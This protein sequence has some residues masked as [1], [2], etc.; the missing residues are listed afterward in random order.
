MSKR[1]PF[2]WC[3]TTL[4]ELR[5]EEFQG[6][7]VAGGADVAVD[8]V[9]EPE[10]GVGGV[11][12]A[13]AVALGVQVRDQAVA[14]GVGEGPE[15]V[16]GLA[17]P[18]GAEGQP[19]E[20]D[21]GVAAPVGEP[22][23][24][25]DHGPQLVAGGAGA[26]GVLDPAGGADEELVGG[27]HQLGGRPG[28]GGPGRLLDQPAAA[29]ELGLGGLLGRQGLDG[30][31]GLGRGDQ[32]HVAAGLQ[33][34]P[35]VAGAPEGAGGGIAAVVLEPVVDLVDPGPLHRVGRSLADEPEP[36]RGQAA[37]LAEL[38]AVAGGRQ[39][40]LAG[41]LLVDLRVVRAEVDRRPELQ[42]ERPVAGDQPVAQVR[43]VLEVGHQQPL[44]DGVP[45]RELVAPDG[46]AVVEA[47]LGEVGGA[48][49]LQ[50]VAAGPLLAAEADDR[51]VGQAE[52]VGEVAEHQGPAVV[53]GQG[54]D[55]QA[56]VAAG[57][58]ARERPRGVAAEAV[59][60]EPL[61]VEQGP[62]VGLGPPPAQRPDRVKSPS[63]CLL[64]LGSGCEQHGGVPGEVPAVGGL[65]LRGAGP[66]VLGLLARPADRPGGARRRGQQGLVDRVEVQGPAEVDQQQAVVVLGPEVADEE[67][68]VVEDRAVDRPPQRRLAAA[69]PE[70]VAVEPV[71]RGSPSP[72]GVVELAA[73]EGLDGPG[74]GQA[75]LDLRQAEVVEL[76]E[77]LVVPLADELRQLGRV[78][79]EVE[80]R[81][82]RGV[83]LALE[84]HRGL[85]RR[86]ARAPS[87][88]GSGRPRRSGG[89]ARPAASWPA[90]RGS[91]G[92]RR[93]ARP[94]GPAPAGPD[95][96]PGG[97]SA[98]PGRASRASGPRRTPGARPGSRRSRRRCGR[99]GRRSPRGGSRRTRRRRSRGRPG[100]PAGGS[101]RPAAR[102][103]RRSGCGDP[104]R[105]RGP[106]G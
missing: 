28:T 32:G 81:P 73:L 33:V 63:G 64:G 86:A 20:A 67:R 12:E 60:H 50:Q 85:R 71:G 47:E 4:G 31:P 61:A 72:L 10:G 21:H 40:V 100:R 37:G 11:V 7:L 6:R 43:G 55:Q 96:P 89:A 24:A 101:P 68:L 27:Q 5:D 93:T 75:G 76:R 15:D 98:G 57:V 74:V 42:P 69:E 44:L 87:S 66:A 83:L 51:A 36:E 80:E 46:Q 65:G 90:G 58:G 14:D 30:R 92:R 49:D 88:P 48:V 104:R 9:E 26:G 84:E 105:R 70:Q 94:G 39:A 19:V 91:P 29:G 78:V 53:A 45:G 77:E 25:G 103:R 62:R 17:G 2:R 102:S 18:A 16:A 3:S 8:G 52:A 54:G 41:Q 38:V 97:R 35:E 13:V 23:V 99:S 106:S 82:G 56:V 34:G 79:H 95:G 22:V 59:G 1:V